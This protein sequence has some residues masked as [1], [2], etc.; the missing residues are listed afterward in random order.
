MERAEERT[1]AISAPG[2]DRTSGRM[3]DVC[4]RPPAWR[5][6]CGRQRR[7]G[8]GTDGGDD[9]MDSGGDDG[10]TTSTSADPVSGTP[11]PP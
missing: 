2:E 11:S 5:Y 9:G 10:A 4:R 1:D 3:R 7:D 6:A 8:D